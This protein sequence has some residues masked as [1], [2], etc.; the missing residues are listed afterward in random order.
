[1]G[2]RNRSPIAWTCWAGTAALTMTAMVLLAVTRVPPDAY[3][4]Q[5]W[6]AALLAMP[7]D[8]LIFPTVG[9]AL[10]VRRGRNPI[11]WL[12][13]GIGLGLVLNESMRLYGEYGL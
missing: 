3:R 1:M 8:Y 10:A 11:G 7:A 2:A 13:M 6:L 12:L 9:L 4:E 5:P